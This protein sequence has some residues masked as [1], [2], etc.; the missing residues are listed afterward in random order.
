[1]AGF[2]VCK[3][4]GEAIGAYEPVVALADGLARESVRSK[5][6]RPSGEVPEC[7]H[8]ACFELHGHLSSSL[9]R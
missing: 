2:L 9:Q 8:R 6:E 1:M 7:Y 3:A 4:C 5:L